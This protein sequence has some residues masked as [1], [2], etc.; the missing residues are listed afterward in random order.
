MATNDIRVLQEQADGSLKETLLTSDF[1]TFAGIAS[2]PATGDAA[3][4]YTATDTNRLY[5]WTGSAYVEISPTPAHVHAI[6]DVTGLQASLDSKASAV[7]WGPLILNRFRGL[8]F[9]SSNYAPNAQNPTG[10]FSLGTP[11]GN[12][13]E[14]WGLDGTWPRIFNPAKM[15]GNGAG[16]FITAYVRVTG[17]FNDG[18]HCQIR[19]FNGV[20]TSIVSGLGDF[21]G[22]TGAADRIL[23]A[24]SNQQTAT[25]TWMSFALFCGAYGN[26]NNSN[27]A[28]IQDTV[29]T[30]YRA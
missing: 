9:A 4:I 28:T 8:Y 23:F 3:K 17:S 10:M 16:Y 12:V 26:N 15:I 30:F 7:A 2:F 27:G 6:A 22:G 24:T 29:L 1:L 13:A 18:I 21:G 19:A 25:D 5:R 14:G 11:V 20:T